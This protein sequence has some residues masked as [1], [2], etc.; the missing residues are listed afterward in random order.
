[1]D[2][3]LNTFLDLILSH[4]RQILWWLLALAF[5]WFFYAALMRARRYRDVNFY[6]DE[7]QYWLITIVVGPLFIPGLL[8][9]VAFNLTY[10]TVMFL[11]FPRRTNPYF[12]QPFLFGMNNFEWT[13]TARLQRLIHDEG[14]R[15]AEARFLCRN[16]VEREDQNHCGSM[17]LP[18]HLVKPPEFRRTHLA[19]GMAVLVAFFLVLK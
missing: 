16:F 13:F 9:D 18:A 2:L 15:G 10:G 11:Q 8:Y 1:M 17:M 19:I 14:W 12:N 3:L 6:K 4:P 5:F 7:W